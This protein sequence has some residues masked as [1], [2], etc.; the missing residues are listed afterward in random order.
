MKLGI[1]G[2]P[3]VGKSTLFNAI[4]N[5]GIPADNYAFCTIDPNVGVVA[6]P[7]V[8]LEWL[9]DLHQPK[10]FTPATIEFVDIA[11]LVKGA[12]KG[13][14]LGNKFLSNIRTTDAIIHVVRCFDDPNV[15]HVEG[16]TDPLRDIDIIN[17][18]LILA[19]AEMCERRMDKAQ[20]AAKGGDKRFLR[21]A[22]VFSAL[23]EHLNEGKLARTF[24][25]SDDDRALIATS[26]LLTLKRTIYA[27][28]VSED[29]VND[30]ES[31]PY[32]QQVKKL[33][34][35]EAFLFRLA[36]NA[37]GA[38][39][40]SPALTAI[41]A[42]RM[43]PIHAMV[44]WDCLMA[45]LDERAANGTVRQDTSRENIFLC[46]GYA[47][48]KRLEYAFYLGFS[49]EEEGYAP[50]I[51]ACYR[52]EDRFT[53]EER[54]IYALALLRGH[55]YQEFYTNGG[56]NDFRHMRPKEHYL[57]HLRRNLALTD[58]DALR[59]QLLQLADLGFLDQDNC[60]AAV[61]LLLRSRLTEATAFLLDY[62]N[63]RW[64]RET[65]GADTDF[66]DA[67]FAL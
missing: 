6:V 44:H 36:T 63:R 66:L 46:Q 19:D 1:V 41:A 37:I 52:Q 35:E 13:E 40:I 34:D 61:D 27:A 20:K 17:L 7:D 47:Q 18:E 23:L 62:C 51:G 29:A 16:S 32:F 30:P 50:E 14:G 15:T 9:R 12:S 54:L 57:E 31:V 24:E 26:D 21:E 48:L 43:R 3:N 42:P 33:A 11:G 28:N 49:L 56:T 60:R 53:G 39:P 67:E 8:R 55:S 64:P 4:T 38:R 5:A 22:E 58:N 2:L 59:R 10:K 45:A 65:A 25:C